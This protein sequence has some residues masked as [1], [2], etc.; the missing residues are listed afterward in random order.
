MTRW[1]CKAALAHHPP[2][3][4]ST[5][6]IMPSTKASPEI[7]MGLCKGMMA[8]LVVL[9]PLLGMVDAPEDAPAVLERSI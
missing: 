1:A 5:S 6:H 4:R 7:K 2:L 3:K 8:L 9:L